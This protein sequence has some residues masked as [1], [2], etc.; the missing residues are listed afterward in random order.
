MD[1]TNGCRIFHPA[2]RHCT[3]FSVA[4]GNFSKI[5]HNL[6][7]NA[8]LNKYKK[9]ERT[10]YMVCDFDHNAIKLEVTNKTNTKNMQTI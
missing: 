1:L 8:S 5:D 6:E 10:P 7:H 2:T 3:F 9:T 4:H